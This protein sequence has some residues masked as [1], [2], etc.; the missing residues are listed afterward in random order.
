M[1]LSWCDS[2]I[3]LNKHPIV[4]SLPCNPVTLS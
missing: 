2:T 3:G 1:G 4:S